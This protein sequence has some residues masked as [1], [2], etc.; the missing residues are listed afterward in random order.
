MSEKE[1]IFMGRKKQQFIALL[2]AAGLLLTMAACG[3][4]GKE[5][6]QTGGETE[7]KETQAAQTA[8]TDMEKDA[9]GGQEVTLDILAKNV[10]ESFNQYA[11]NHVQDKMAEDIGVRIHMVNADNDKFTI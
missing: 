9:S 2:S 7:G 1:G 3:T 6:V 4:S 5:P 8:E 10:G 11:D